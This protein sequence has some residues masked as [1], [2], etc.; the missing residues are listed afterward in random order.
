MAELMRAVAEPEAEVADPPLHV[1]TAGGA[2]L[3]GLLLI[4]SPG[5]PTEPEKR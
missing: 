2:L 4:V 1:P 5:N 3:A